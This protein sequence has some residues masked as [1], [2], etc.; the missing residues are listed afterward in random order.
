MNRRSL[1]IASIRMGGR[2]LV[3]ASGIPVLFPK[4]NT[5]FADQLLPLPVLIYWSEFIA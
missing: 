1:S 3:P 2:R 5:Y 4:P